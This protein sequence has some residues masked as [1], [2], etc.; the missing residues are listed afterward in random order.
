MQGDSSR[1]IEQLKQTWRSVTVKLARP[2]VGEYKLNIALL[3]KALVKYKGNLECYVD[4]K[5]K[6]W[7]DLGSLKAFVFAIWPRWQVEFP[8]C[9]AVPKI[10]ENH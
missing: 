7:G 9:H 8:R 5:L 1:Y 10:F 2:K 4:E 6:W 3:Y